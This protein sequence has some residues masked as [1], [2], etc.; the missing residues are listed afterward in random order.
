M[1]I[2]NIFDEKNEKSDPGMDRSFHTD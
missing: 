1:G 2:L